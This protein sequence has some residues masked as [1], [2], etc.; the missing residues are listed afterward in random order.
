MKQAKSDG[1]FFH[2]GHGKQFAN[3]FQKIIFSPKIDKNL[4]EFVPWERN[5]YCSLQKCQFNLLHGIE[6]GT[7]CNND[8]DRTKYK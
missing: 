8:M 6:N 3:L 5:F 1:F 7:K 2:F 4:I